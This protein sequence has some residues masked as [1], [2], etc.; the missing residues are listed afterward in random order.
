V[1]GSDKDPEVS[2]REKGLDIVWPGP[3]ELFLDLDDDEAFVLFKKQVEIL[4]Q[5]D[6]GT[7]TEA[8]SVNGGRHVVVTLDRP[9]TSETE[10]VMLEAVL[11]SDRKRSLLGLKQL[12]RGRE[13]TSCFFK[14]P[15]NRF[16]A[17]TPE[18]VNQAKAD[19]RSENRSD[20]QEDGG[21]W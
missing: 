8:R 7:W 19:A 6:K 4:G 1:S 3:C 2:A 12:R 16:G 21:L 17:P 18:D 9:L 11:G 13:R 10:R 20:A 14:K 5:F 15:P